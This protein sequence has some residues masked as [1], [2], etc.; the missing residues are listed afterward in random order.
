VEQIIVTRLDDLNH[1]D[2][3]EAEVVIDYGGNKFLKSVPFL[4]A[5]EHRATKFPK[6]EAFIEYVKRMG[7]A[8]IKQC[9]DARNPFPQELVEGAH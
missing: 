4:I 1:G 2:Y 9:G 7:N 5:K 3:I 8:C 6:H